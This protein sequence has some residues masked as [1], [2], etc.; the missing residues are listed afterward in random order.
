MKKIL[1]LLIIVVI[2][3]IGILILLRKEIA[4]KEKVEFEYLKDI[5]KFSQ[6]ENII[7]QYI[8]NIVSSN[9]DAAYK[10]VDNKYITYE[11]FINLYNEYPNFE[12]YRYRTDYMKCA[13]KDNLEI[14]H[15]YGKMIE[16]PLSVTSQEEDMN[17]IIKIDTN[18]KL[19]SITP[20]N[21]KI[22]I[23]KIISVSIEDKEFNKVQDIEKYDDT[24]KTIQYCNYFLNDVILDFNRAYNM[25]DENYKQKRFKNDIYEFAKYIKENYDIKDK[26][27]GEYIL[28]FEDC[29]LKENGEITEYLSEISSTSSYIFK[30]EYSNIFKVLLD[31]YTIE[32]EVAK[33]KYNNLTTEEKIKYNCH[34]IIHSLGTQYYEYSYEHLKPSI[35]EEKY[36]TMEQYKNYILQNHLKGYEI[37]ENETVQA[38]N[39]SYVYYAELKKMR[40]NDKK[41]LE[42]TM[43]LKENMDFEMSF[44]IYQSK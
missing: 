33:Q 16:Y 6:V 12:R 10:M 1:V 26:N 22:D 7:E 41:S 20:E 44:E 31:R 8:G 21:K 35:K 3:I 43:N 27:E 37:L 23:N 36:K 11:K 4:N 40:S 17:F 28:F 19:F 25:L 14:Y 9:L 42:I 34:N 30:E 2:L 29:S 39:E 18:K 32:T 5:N 15:V 24:E 13:V 38:N